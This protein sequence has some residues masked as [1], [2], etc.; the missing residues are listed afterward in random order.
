MSVVEVLVSAMHQKDL[1]IVYDT[2]IASDVLLINQCDRNELLEVFRDFGRVRCISTTERGL[3]RSRNM[4][5]RN[6]CGE[7]CLICDD[8]EILYSGY[9][10]EIETAYQKYPDADIICFKIK[11]EE[12]KYSD[13]PMKINY[14]TAL[15]VF[16]CQISFKL[17]K[18]IESG[19]N[20]DV[21]FGSGTP[22]GSGEE[23]IFL[24]DC[25][26]AGLKIYYVPVLI[27]EVAQ[28]QSGWFKGFTEEYFIN[29][30]TIVTKMM[31][32][33]WGF[34]Y[35]LYFA[36]SKYKRYNKNLSFIESITFMIKGIKR[37]L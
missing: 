34:V 33:F 8:D 10:N 21:N 12:K 29:K 6:A 27:G 2:N 20:F 16:S 7:Y 17:K 25:L 4:A 36:V 19:I 1:S 31:G 32:K 5:L 9:Q 13:K 11:R 14:V 26:K 23:N 3:S 24:Y 37:E 28:K 30:G 22:I 18:I 35:C 15:Q